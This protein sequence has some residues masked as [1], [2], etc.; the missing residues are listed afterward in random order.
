[1][2]ASDGK[3]YGTTRYGG[4]NDRGVVFS[5][6]PSSRLFTKE[7]DFPATGPGSPLFG[8]FIEV[9]TK[10]CPPVNSITVQTICRNQLPYKWNGQ[11]YDKSGTYQVKLLSSRGCDSIAT[12]NLTV[13]EMTKAPSVSVTEPSCSAPGSIKITTP[14]TGLSYSINGTDYINTTGIFDNLVAGTYT[15]TIKN[16]QGCISEATVV[17]LHQPQSQPPVPAVTSPVEYCQAVTA[18]PLKA[19]ALPGHSLRWYTAATAGT[20]SATAP[21]PSTSSPGQ[22]YYYVSQVNNEGC[23][24]P[25]AE[26]VVKTVALPVVNIK[27]STTCTGVTTIVA[28]PATGA[29]NEYSFVWTVPVGAG[30]PGNVASLNTTTPGNYSVKIVGKTT[31]CSSASASLNVTTS[32]PMSATI[33]DAK[34]LDSGVNVNT[35]YIGYKPAEAITISAKVTEGTA[36]FSYTWSNGQTTASISVSPTTATIYTVTVKDAAGCQQTTTKEIKIIDVRC[37]DKVKICRKKGNSS[38]ETECMPQGAVADQIASGAYLGECKTGG[39][40]LEPGNTVQDAATTMNQLSVGVLPNPSTNYF[41]L[42]LKTTSHE[43]LQIAIKD[44]VGRLV[45]TIRPANRN[46]SVKIGGGYW[47]GIYYAEVI[48]G[49]KRKVVK[50]LK[51]TR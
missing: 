25:K 22:T 29:A 16:T 43:P 1:M 4:A 8:F 19:V 51:Q 46:S 48:Q 11:N 14:E 44:E 49:N 40:I 24:S 3:L 17:T 41:T 10:G 5:I 13:R 35:V 9:K 12:L 42:V 15:V 20:A 45:E 37:D 7:K 32:G 31:N 33:P 38:F 47:P 36:P 18:T 30:I 2:Q 50:L 26:V 27:S 34:A 6:D 23:E 28:T 21:T 39:R